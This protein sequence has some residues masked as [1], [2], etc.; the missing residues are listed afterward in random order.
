MKKIMK[1]ILILI[2]IIF[3]F[4]LVK[5]I[6]FAWVVDIPEH[7][8]IT[9]IS[10]T[11]N[12]KGDIVDNVNTIG[13]SLLKTVKVVLQWVLLIFLVYVGVQMIMAMGNDEQL[14]NARRQIMYAMIGLLFINI[15]WTIYEAFH[16]DGNEY[17]W[18]QIGQSWFETDR[19]DNNIFIDFFDFWTTF[20]DN[21]IW[22]LKV[23]IFGIA[24]FMLVYAGIE[25]MTARE[26]QEQIGEWK[27]K[28]IY[29]ILALI[30]LWFIESWK[31][32]AFNWNISDGVNLFETIANLGL[33]F[34][35]PTALFFLT[36]AG[37]YYITS[38]GDEEKVKKAKSIVIN[39]VLATLIILAAYT[40][41]LDIAKL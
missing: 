35:G 30:F 41:L 12:Q 5:E 8:D 27:E 26:R 6:S 40:F 2:S 37:Y 3:S 24:V 25:I 1:K 36:L 17:I 7:E 14:S 15:P 38:N 10:I 33:F 13:F 31:N 18:W 9:N 39:I 34:A 29:V 21:I 32:V 20:N 23:L 28:I 16:R 22:F 11:Y 19:N 4:F